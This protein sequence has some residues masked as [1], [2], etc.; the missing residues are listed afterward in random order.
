MNNVSDHPSSITT[1]SPHPT[2]P[3]WLPILLVVLALLTIASTV[4]PAA[5]QQR[6]AA[7]GFPIVL[8]FWLSVTLLSAILT[9]AA[10]WRIMNGGEHD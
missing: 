7:L 10:A 8:W 1:L 9:T 3:V 6:P 5:V 4:L 2:L